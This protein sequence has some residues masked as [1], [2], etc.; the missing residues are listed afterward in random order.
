MLPITKIPKI[1]SRKRRKLLYIR[2][3]NRCHRMTPRFG[4]PWHTDQKRF[5]FGSATV[6]LPSRYKQQCFTIV[7]MTQAFEDQ[8]TLRK[9]NQALKCIAKVPLENLEKRVKRLKDVGNE[10]CSVVNLKEVNITE[11]GLTA[12]ITTGEDSITESLIEE[13]IDDYYAALCEEIKL[14]KFNN[15][16]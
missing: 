10:Q 6:R 11:V 14:A 13:I 7:I 4:I 9:L 5:Q 8:H 12:R 15:G 3:K 16:Y 1:M 2:L